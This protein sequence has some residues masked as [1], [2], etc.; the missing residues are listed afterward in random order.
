MPE[1]D[2]VAPTDPVP[3]TVPALHRVMM[4]QSRPKAAYPAYGDRPASKKVIGEPLMVKR[5]ENR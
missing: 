2:P 1:P 5:L 3:T 4:E